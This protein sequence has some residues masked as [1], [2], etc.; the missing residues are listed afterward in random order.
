M[1]EA[2]GPD[3]HLLEW[4]CPEDD[5]ALRPPP[6]PGRQPGQL[7]PWEVLRKKRDAVPESSFRRYFMNQHAAT[8]ESAWLPAGAWQRAGPTT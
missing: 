4:S 8:G 2:K 5:E 7:A 6:H 3:L 1:V